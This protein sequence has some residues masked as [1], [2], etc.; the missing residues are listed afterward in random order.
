ML[1]TLDPEAKMKIWNLEWKLKS[2]ELPT[3]NGIYDCPLKGME[4]MFLFS[5]IDVICLILYI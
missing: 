3:H 4:W 1:H 2:L 5:S